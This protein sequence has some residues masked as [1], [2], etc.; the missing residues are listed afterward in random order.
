MKKMSYN[1]PLGR[2]SYFPT[3]DPTSIYIYW[4]GDK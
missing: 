2:T 3:W 1:V 4:C